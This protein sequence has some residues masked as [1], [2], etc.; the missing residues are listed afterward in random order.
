ML[1]P[2]FKEYNIVTKLVKVKD[3]DS[4]KEYLK[5]DI[6]GHLEQC[7]TLCNGVDYGISS[8]MDLKLE[9]AECFCHII[10]AGGP[11]K[12]V[13]VID[14]GIDSE[15]YK[16][17]WATTLSDLK[18]AGGIIPEKGDEKKLTAVWVELEK[19]YKDS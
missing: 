19:D 13:K 5:P 17:H 6:D 4:G 15:E 9:G 11:P 18:N 12:N 8:I 7:L 10:M 1:G 16:R 14:N 3:E 2:Y